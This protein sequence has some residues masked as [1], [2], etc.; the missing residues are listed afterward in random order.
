M[1]DKSPQ[2]RQDQDRRSGNAI[3]EFALLVPL[4]TVLF[5]GVLT[6]GLTLDRY[7]T[8]QQLARNTASIFSRGFDFTL[9]KNQQLVLRSATGLGMKPQGGDGVIYISKVVLAPPGSSNAGELVVSERYVI[10]D[11]D[12]E[13]SS[14]ATPAPTHWPDETQPM[15]NGFVRDYI[16]E[17]SARASLP[18][19]PNTPL[20][21][22]MVDLTDTLFVVE[23]HHKADYLAFPEDWM[24]SPERL[25]TLV[26]F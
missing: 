1:S 20:A 5:L 22:G 14:V 23:V 8:I 18:L 17:A 16:N 21:S 4:L 13:P 25:S 9:V 3:V 26:V 19:T 24:F 15:P 6:A 2:I 12:L 7:M 11:P 10:G